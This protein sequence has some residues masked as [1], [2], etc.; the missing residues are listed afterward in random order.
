MSSVS[1]PPYS[2]H[3]PS[4]GTARPIRTSPELESVRG[5]A[6]LGI[7]LFHIPKWHPALDIQFKNNCY[8]MVDVFFVLSGY[9][10]FSAYGAQI[11]TKTDFLRFIFLR[12]GR[13]YPV[14][15]L[16]LGLFLFL[17]IGKYLGMMYLPDLSL[18]NPPFTA[19]SLTALLEHLLL[20]QAIGPTGNALTFNAPAWSIS[21]EFLAYVLFG[22]LTLSTKSACRNGLIALAA[23]VAFLLLE[24]GEPGEYSNL[25]RCILG[26]SIGC[27]TAHVSRHIK[28]WSNGLIG[29][30]AGLVLITYLQ[31][32]TPLSADSLIYFLAAVIILAI[33]GRDEKNQRSFL[34]SRP[35]IWLGEI[36]YSVYMAHMFVLWAFTSAITRFAPRSLITGPYGNK[37]V[38][39]NGAEAAVAVSLIF[40]T[41]ILLGCLVSRHVELPLRL[42]SRRI[43]A[44]L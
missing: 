4:L 3:P 33:T 28:P 12:L 43:A 36:S 32:K 11:R 41:A 35:L 31:I 29:I 2:W 5:L 6:A 13:L 30:L 27:L 10:I 7:I 34:H 19:N 15:L 23:C 9:V 37:V 40:A 18:A 44:R 42:L 17:E 24:F 8:L 14:H 1:S 21:V 22:L 26:F 20:I 38:A 39:L 25:L 16:F